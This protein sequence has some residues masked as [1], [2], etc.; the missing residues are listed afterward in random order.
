[1]SICEHTHS[2]IPSDTS[3]G[4]IIMTGVK[5]WFPLVFSLLSLM[6]PALCGVSAEDRCLISAGSHIAAL[7]QFPGPWSDL[8]S[9]R[10]E[11][12]SRLSAEPVSQPRA[13][14]LLSLSSR[15]IKTVLE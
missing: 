11:E 1:M 15:T 7:S 9:A 6:P 3:Q 2:Q 8:R 14:T 10:Q 5:P 13:I 12:H 4:I